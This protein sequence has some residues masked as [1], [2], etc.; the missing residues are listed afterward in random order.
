MESAGNNFPICRGLGGRR[1]SDSVPLVTTRKPGHAVALPPATRWFRREGEIGKLFPDC[2]YRGP[3]RAAWI[4]EVR[5]SGPYGR[6]HHAPKRQAGEA[7]GLRASPSA[8]RSGPQRPGRSRPAFRPMLRLSDS[9][10]PE[11]QA[12]AEVNSNSSRG[13]NRRP[14]VPGGSGTSVLDAAPRGRRPKAAS[15]RRRPR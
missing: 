10:K 2:S 6:P 14:V 1:Q 5:N 3:P 9:G 7:Q 11:I 15:R 13:S 4:E 12:S 8:N